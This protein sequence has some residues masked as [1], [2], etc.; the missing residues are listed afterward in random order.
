MQKME[1]MELAAHRDDIVA[2][3]KRL[4]DKYRAIFEWD[5]PETDEK[6]ADKLIVA[7]IRKALSE[8]ENELQN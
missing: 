6:L 8:L 3:V 5:V 2:D 1:Q 7:E 4:V